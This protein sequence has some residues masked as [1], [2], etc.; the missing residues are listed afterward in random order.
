MSYWRKVEIQSVLANKQEKR[1]LLT[2]PFYTTMR[3]AFKKIRTI[4]GKN[5]VTEYNCV[6][7]VGITKDISQS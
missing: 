3:A 5:K 1:W 6:T 2:W 7:Q 4:L